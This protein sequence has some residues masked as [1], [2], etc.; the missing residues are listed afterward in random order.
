MS[1]ILDSLNF[2]IYIYIYS[3]ISYISL[4][5]NNKLNLKNSYTKLLLKHIFIYFLR[6]Y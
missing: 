2:L 4:K 1:C 5:Q 6:K 3:T